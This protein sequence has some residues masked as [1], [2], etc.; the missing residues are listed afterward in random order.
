MLSTLKQEKMDTNTTYSTCYGVHPL[1]IPHV[2][3]TVFQ[4]CHYDDLKTA[5]LVCSQWNQCT[6]KSFGA[7]SCL[8][9]R[10]YQELNNFME[11]RIDYFTSSEDSNT[12]VTTTLATKDLC[13]HVRVSGL[14][15]QSIPM[16]LR[17][18]LLRL[19]PYLKTFEIDHGHVSHCPSGIEAYLRELA[20]S[21]TNVETLI[22]IGSHLSYHP[23]EAI[24]QF[25]IVLP[26]VKT[27]KVILTTFTCPRNGYRFFQEVLRVLP[28]LE[29]VSCVKFPFL[30][31]YTLGRLELPA[32]LNSLHL[33]LWN[34]FGIQE[35]ID[36]RLPI[37]NLRINVEVCLGLVNLHRLLQSLSFTL[38]NVELHFM[39]TLRNGAYNYSHNA[40][41]FPSAPHLT[42]LKSLRLIGYWGHLYFLGQMPRLQMV[43]VHYMPRKIAFPEGVEDEDLLPRRIRKRIKFFD[44]YGVYHAL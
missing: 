2:L 10:G 28:N 23:R 6:S 18:V 15:F 26:S 41:A 4:Y 31:L 30:S 17:P 29:N 39:D 25:N 42:S 19:S 5:R 34:G 21:T 37:T 3:E 43:S 11:E 13:S 32:Q 40:T 7:Q 8:H 24:S 16:L 38:E 36:R 1:T 44:K 27:L 33:H 22:L 14:E 20:L 35:F 12:N 9:F